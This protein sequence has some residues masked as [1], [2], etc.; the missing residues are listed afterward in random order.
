MASQFEKCERL[1]NLHEGSEAFVIPN[2][3]DTGSARL[4]QGLGFSALATTSSGL[5]YTLGR[6]DGEISMEEKLAHCLLLSG[7]TEIPVSA[8]FENGFADDPS[9]AALNVMRLAETGVAGCSI[10]DFSRESKELYDFN[11]SIERIHA[12]VEAIESLG[13]PFQ[14]TARAENLL[15]GVDDL[16][17]TI[18]R[19]K[20]FEKAGADVLYAPGIHTLDQLRIVT[21]ELSKPFNVLASFLP[22]AT[23]DEFAKAG[24]KRISIGGALNWL[25]VNAV[26]EAG[27]EMMQQGSFTWHRNVA[28]GREVNEL[29]DAH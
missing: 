25:A 16:D 21:S 15:R 29:L 8:D 27:N 4:L 7:A 24:A 1:K 12:T 22:S 18:G 28:S 2:P 5:A 26:I 14:L 17:D 9:D 19:L 6:K 23:V 10:E 20:A 11:F 13:I 3:W